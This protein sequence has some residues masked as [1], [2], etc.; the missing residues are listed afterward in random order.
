MSSKILTPTLDFVEDGELRKIIEDAIQYIYIVFDQ[1][2]NSDNDLFKEETYRVIILY[3]I[4]VIEAIL[5]YVLKTRNDQIKYTE[6]KYA[7]SLPKEFYHSESP[8][9][10]VIIAV[11]KEQ[12]KTDS[13][14]GLVEFGRFYEK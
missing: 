3:I 14:I 12:I 1:T 6:Y 4:S 2:K 8:K 7:S 10:M 11:K 5:L 13:Q 9:D